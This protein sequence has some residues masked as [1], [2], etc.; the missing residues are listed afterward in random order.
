MFMSLNSKWVFVLLP[1]QL[2]CRSYAVIVQNCKKNEA[3]CFL[4]KVCLVSN[5]KCIIVKLETSW[6]DVGWEVYEDSPS[7]A[8][9]YPPRK[10]YQWKDP[11]V[12]IY[13]TVSSYR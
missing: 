3:C 1:I 2:W 4:G 13:L 12:T 11:T 6:K 5:L 8:L 7:Y 9:Q 10:E